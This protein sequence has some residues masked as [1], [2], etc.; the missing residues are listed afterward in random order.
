MKKRTW[1]ASLTA[2]MLALQLAIPMPEVRG[3]RTTNAPVSI[4]AVQAQLPDQPIHKLVGAKARYAPNEEVQMTLTLDNQMNWQGTLH[5]EVYHIQHLVATGTKPIQMVANTQPE[6]TFTWEPPGTDFR[7]YL[8]KA[9]VEGR[10]DEF[11]TAAVDVS[12]DWTR[13]PRYGY[14]TEFPQESQQQS[15]EK[16]KEL[17]QEYYLNGYQFYDWMWRHDVSVYSETD[18]EGK[19]VLDADGN[20]ISAPIDEET[21]Y[22]DLLGRYLYPLTVKQQVTSAQK[23]GSAAMAYQMNYAAREHYEDFGVQREWGLYRKNATFPNPDP[24]KFQEG[25][26]FDWVTPPTALYL[27]DPGN[28]EWQAY[29]TKEFNRAANEFGFDGMHLDQWGWWDGGFLYDYFGNERYFSLDYDALINAVKN[30]LETNNPEQSDVTFNMVG[31]NGGYS[32]VPKPSTL[33]DFD[34]SEIWQDMDLYRDLKKVINDTRLSNGGK[35]MVIA[36]YMNYKQAA[37]QHY[38]AADVQDVPRTVVFQSRIAHIPGWVGDFG[39]KDEDQI[40]WT[41]DAA[42]AGTA[43]LKLVYG[44]GNDSGYPEGRLTVNGTVAASQIAFDQ[45]TGWGNPTAEAVVS[46]ELQAGSNEIRLQLNTSDKWLNI[47]SLMVKQGAMEQIYEAEYAELISSKIDKV[48]HVYYFETDGDY[49]S[50][51]VEADAAGNYPL[52]FHY[53][54]EQQPVMRELTVNGQAYG[55]LYFESTGDWEAFEALT[56]PDV[57][58]QAGTNTIELKVNGINDQGMKLDALQL[59]AQYYEAENAAYGW[60]PTQQAQIQTQEGTVLRN[61]VTQVKQSPDWIS[62]PIEDEQAASAVL[63]YASSNTPQVDVTVNGAVYGQPLDLSSTGGWGSEG[64]WQLEPLPFVN[65]PGT[66]TLRLTMK[67]SGQ[68]MDVDGLFL[69]PQEVLVSDS[70]KVST[71]GTMSVNE[72]QANTDDFNGANGNAITFDVDAAQS[73][74]QTIM[75]WYRTGTD[76]T[77]GTL[78][79]NGTDMPVAFANNGWYGGDWWGTVEVQANLN[80]GSNSLTLTLDRADTYL[81]LH[82]V[83]AGL[84]LEAEA[85]ETGKNGVQTQPT[86]IGDFGQSGDAATFAVTHDTNETVAL[87]WIY[88]ADEA[89]T[90][91]IEVNGQLQSVTFPATD[92]AWSTLTMNP[93]LIAGSNTILMKPQQTLSTSI[94]LDGWQL[95]GNQIEAETALQQAQGQATTASEPGE[96]GY[97]YDFAQKGD[98][99]KVSTDATSTSGVKLLTIYYKNEGLSTKR[100][101]YV[102]GKKAGL[103]TLEPAADWTAVQM[104]IYLDQADSESVILIKQEQ[105]DA[106]AVAIDRFELEGLSYEAEAGT[107]GWEPVVAP[108][109]EISTSPGKTDNHGN[110]GQTVRFMV[111]A[112]EDLD[113]MTFTYRSGNNP[114]FDI[115]VDGE[116]VLDDITFGA[117]PG[118]W[119]GGMGEKTVDVPLTTGS[120]T[121][122]LVM[123]TQ[124]QYVNLDSLIVGETEYEAEDA[125]LFPVDHGMTVSRGVVEGFQDEGDFIDFTVQ[126]E[127][128]GTYTL[129]W[130]YLNQ[131]TSGRTAVRTVTVNDT[132]TEEV[133]FQNDTQWQLLS[134]TGVPL[135][136]GLNTI[137]IQVADRDDDGVK[138]DYLQIGTKKLHAEKAGFVPPMTIYKDVITNFG[139]PGDEVTFDIELDRAGETSLIFTYS[140]E[141]ATATRTLYIDG[142]PVLGSDGKPVK[143]WFSATENK[144][145]FNEDIYYIVPHLES[146]AHE[147][148][149]KYE[150]DDKG[151]INLRKMTVGFFDEP[152]VRLMDAG[153]A[154]MGATHIELGTAEDI[155]EGPNM[156]AHEYY[157]NRS[158]KMTASLKAAMKEYYK[159]FA[160]YENIL[161][162]SVEDTQAQISVTDRDGQMLPVSSDG[163]KQS[164]WTIVRENTT[165]T[166][167]EQ[168][169]LIH[170]INLLNNDDN[171]RNEANEPQTQEQLRVRYETGITA[172]DAPNLAVH[173]A[174]PD[175]NQGLM[176]ELTFVWEGSELVIDVPELSYWTMLVLDYEPDS[177][178]VSSLF[179]SVTQPGNPRS[180][181]GSDRDDD[182]DQDGDEDEEDLEEEQEVRVIRAE[183]LKP[184]AKGRIVITLQEQQRKVRMPAEIVTALSDREE[185]EWQAGKRTVVLTGKQLKDMLRA[186]GNELQEKT[187]LLMEMKPE[188]G[189]HADKLSV[190]FGGKTRIQQLDAWSVSMEL[191]QEDGTVTVVQ[192]DVKLGYRFDNPDVTGADYLIGLYRYDDQKNKWLF[193]APWKEGQSMPVVQD[194]TYALLHVEVAYEDLQAADWSHEA[195]QVLSA[196]GIVN[197]DTAGRFLPE[198]ATTRAQFAVLLA[199]LLNLDTG[200]AGTVT[201]FDDVATD[202]WYAGAVQAASEAGLVYGRGEGQ[203]DPQGLLTREEMVALMVRAWHYANASEMSE[204]FSEKS[205]TQG[206]RALF[207]DGDVISDWAQS[208]IMEAYQLGLVKGNADGTFEPEDPSKRK[209]GAQMLYNW[210]R[211]LEDN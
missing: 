11:V 165:N 129:D 136:D 207:S 106:Q 104:P 96:V 78:N 72:S 193:T 117:T 44:H 22:M 183:D 169:E 181:G 53:G 4:Q 116:I 20:F 92:G 137:T 142:E 98:F 171:W 5:V 118:G 119:N 60:N 16:F 173:A 162:D 2:G 48:G 140:N 23:Y 14:T 55:N 49:V 152:S 170:L 63:K 176:Q 206:L 182:A 138:L 8:V 166:G 13:Y 144:D 66:D 73:G 93:S 102:N 210:I 95:D 135:Q 67:S 178:A 139:H 128:A 21:A 64:R 26:F 19:P 164:L 123:V 191:V 130:A 167:F 148:T 196:R 27:Q 3:E 18:A 99:L 31:G 68:F 111:E 79:V 28:P 46:V 87:D 157:P 103:I 133:V 205:D 43:E 180:G 45:Q 25:Y 105:E 188:T 61:Y 187:S 82:G 1:I 150:E 30:A 65:E 211:Q 174:T 146:G 158:K 197:G 58:L 40:V 41:V 80:A 7:G 189:A 33:T 110:T 62:F 94:R 88:Q 107:T 81:N 42:Q 91:E 86:F 202:S 120:H 184:N 15:D 90:Y 177:V 163:S 172:A 39:K 126:M 74:T 71:Q 204:P 132:W 56:V 50:F 145:A 192:E 134:Q 209:E 200:K 122:D 70:S 35:A 161:F 85:A 89:L 124:G 69:N 198:Q 36:A 186:G 121:V 149:L 76:N 17:S 147:V 38:D 125:Q 156:L 9:Y 77:T 203:F 153:L 57:P 101:I 114:V 75:L 59:G 83:V 115:L 108:V 185:V 84:K 199:G 97:V 113:K 34:Y 143:I 51:H 37:G 112:R 54:I 208:A 194:T 168:V 195:V 160:A 127:E 154:A 175:R 109:G 10:E 52:V 131:A 24:V 201:A 141:G 159:F 100:A 47:D 29:I 179:D 32:E 155:T 6:L 12:S 190:S 151:S